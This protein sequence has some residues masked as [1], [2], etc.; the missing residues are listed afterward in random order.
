MAKGNLIDELHLTIRVPSDLPDADAQA[1]RRTLAGRD[2]MSR[3]R[4][5]VRAVVRAFPGL[6]P[7]RVSITR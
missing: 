5:A 3:L 2:F 7:V 4:S 6:A 1:V